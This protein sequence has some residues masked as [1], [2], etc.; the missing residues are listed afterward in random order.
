MDGNSEITLLDLGILSSAIVNNN[1]LT[2]YQYWAGDLDY[3][4]TASVIDI[5]M[6]ADLV[7]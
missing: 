5:L 3:N 6:L 2:Q 1:E 4:G 7:E